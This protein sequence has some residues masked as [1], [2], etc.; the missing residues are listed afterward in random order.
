MQI[1]S[2]GD[3]MKRQGLFSRKNK[4]TTKKKQKKKHTHKKNKTKQ[5]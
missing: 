4:K 1:V 3:S 5:K 2:L